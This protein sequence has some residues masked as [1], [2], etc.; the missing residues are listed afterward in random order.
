MSNVT[1]SKDFVAFGDQGQRPPDPQPGRVVMVAPDG[2]TVQVMNEDVSGF[3]ERGFV[4]AEPDGDPAAEAPA[5]AKRTK[6]APA[7][8]E[9]ES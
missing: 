4:L 7:E 3:T 2:R 1:G 8:P 6:T 5:R 9:E